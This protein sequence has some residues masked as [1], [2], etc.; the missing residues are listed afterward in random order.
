M[1]QSTGGT[2]CEGV[3]LYNFFRAYPNPI[4]LYNGGQ[5]CSSAV[6]AFLG[7]PRRI[8]N[9]HATFM[10]HR[11]QAAPMGADLSRMA[12]TYQSLKIDDERTE[13]ILRDHLTLS[14]EQWELYER[15]MLWLTAEAA[16]QAGLATEIGNFSVPAGT[17][18]YDFGFG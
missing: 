8:V 10:I 13:T 7:A 2:V 18:I 12:A 16:V 17:Q 3:Y 6:T 1:I 15:H 4:S 11:V 5:V 14:A 9:P